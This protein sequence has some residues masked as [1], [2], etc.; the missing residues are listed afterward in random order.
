MSG[1]PTGWFLRLEGPGDDAFRFELYASTRQEELDAWGWPA[2]MRRAFLEMQFKTQAGYRAMFPR[3]DFQIVLLGSERVGRLVVERASAEHRLVDI[4]LL[5]AHRNGGLGTALLRALQSEARAAGK[6]LRLTVQ[7]GHRAARLYARLGFV[8]CG[9][10][11]LHED[12]EFPTI[13][14]I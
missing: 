1:N 11:E 12:M 6:P 2:E 3:A 13:S 9:E 14:R 7:K 5:P 8:K 10:T 4:A